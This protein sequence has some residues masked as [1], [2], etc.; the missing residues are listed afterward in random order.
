M[1][2]TTVLWHLGYMASYDVAITIGSPYEL[3]GVAAR[4]P[5]ACLVAGPYTRSNF[6]ST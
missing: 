2:P 3:H 5:P 1:K 4:L 6:S